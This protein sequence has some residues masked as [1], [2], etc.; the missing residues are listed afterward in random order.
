MSNPALPNNVER[1]W[2]SNVLTVRASQAVES[3]DA[4]VDGDVVPGDVVIEGFANL[5]NTPIPILDLYVNYFLPGAFALSLAD[6]AQDVLC[7]FNH[8]Y[9]KLL[10]RRS[11][12]TASFVEK[13]EGLWSSVRLP[14]GG[15]GP[16][17]AEAVQ[18]GDLQGQSITFQV[19]E[20]TWDHKV[21]PPIRYIS[22]AQLYEAGPV[23]DPA[24]IS[25][26]I[27]EAQMQSSRLQAQQL[28]SMQI[29]GNDDRGADDRVR[30]ELDLAASLL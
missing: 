30:L 28:V 19:L 16:W 17:V 25:T 24:C 26:T 18:R 6:P 3:L 29:S 23:T 5:Y 27:G 22:R 2:G 11:A 9:S 13:P 21:D 1:L 20:C 4:S 8:D 14:K 10:G 12:G 7:C 15:E